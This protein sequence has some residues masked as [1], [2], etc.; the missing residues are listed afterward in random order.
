MAF[1]ENLYIENT[2]CLLVIPANY[3]TIN[4]QA[5]SEGFNSQYSM[6][7]Y[8]DC[9]FDIIE[10][11]RMMHF[12]F[13]FI[14]SA[15]TS[16]ILYSKILSLLIEY[17]PS[18]PR[19]QA[20]LCLVFLISTAKFFSYE[21]VHWYFYYKASD[22]NSIDNEDLNNSSHRIESKNLWD[23]DMSDP[24][25]FGHSVMNQRAVHYNHK[26]PDRLPASNALL[27]FSFILY[28]FTFFA[29]WL[30]LKDSPESLITRSQ[31]SKGV[32]LLK[33]M[34]Q[35]NELTFVEQ[36]V[37]LK[38]IASSLINEEYFNRENLQIENSNVSNKK[39]E[40]DS[41]K[42][43]SIKDNDYYKLFVLGKDLIKSDW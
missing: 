40:E 21:V 29:V 6:L 17:L 23:F 3:L 13:F 9:F 35:P 38:R 15:L 12:N 30:L 31:V 28:V 4:K 5:N 8:F 37:I 16:G 24:E 25:K 2:N 10:N 18:K 14:V 32:V 43:P 33:A 39:P 11:K 26:N 20:F 34:I 19:S 36:Y 27:L 22:A 41:N 7:D 42:K 1:N